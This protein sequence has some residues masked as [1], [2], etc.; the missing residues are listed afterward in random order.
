MNAAVDGDLLST[1]SH[2]R[3]VDAVNVPIRTWCSSV[4][5]EREALEF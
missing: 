5:F 4:V 2:E 1:G 3:F